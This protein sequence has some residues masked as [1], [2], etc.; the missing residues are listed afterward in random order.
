MT[1]VARVIAN[2]QAIHGVRMDS[3][4]TLPGLLWDNAQQT[5]D[6]VTSIIRVSYT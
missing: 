2:V 6:V 5:P 3:N 1:L 4:T